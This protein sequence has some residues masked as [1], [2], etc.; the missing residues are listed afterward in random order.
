MWRRRV[1]RSEAGQVIP[2]VAVM[3]G[4]LIGMI[5]FAVDVGS[6]YHD[7]R[8]MQ[9]IADASALAGAESLP[10]D[11]TSA[12]NLAQTYSTK[13]GGP[14]PTVTFPTANTIQVV[15]QT[16]SPAFFSGNSS[17][18]ITAT[19]R[20]S[21][22][23]VS[24]AAGAVPIV[25]NNTQPMLTG[26][27]GL[28]CFGTTTTLK[29]NDDT[30]LGG[31]QTGLIDL[32]SGGDGSVTAG[33]I[34][35]WVTYGLTTPMPPNQFYSSAGSCKFSNQNFHNALDA[36]IGTPL[37]FP[38][39]D[40]LETNSLSN[41]PRYWITGWAAFVVTSYRLN[42]CGNKSDFIQ[43]YFTREV[44]TGASDGTATPDYGVR[45]ISLSGD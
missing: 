11:S 33:Q 38:V 28:P 6:W 30:S 23:Q 10:Y 44:V 29:V 25:V 31:G 14:A 16:Q 34:A 2:F 43:G 18:T 9:A 36:K 13:N 21:A 35:D 37:L 42:G 41:P 1:L 4:G 3:A 17:V 20:A 12:A 22:P 7:H 45:V 32:R 26:C 40:P 27:S 5:A 15:I 8:R 39:Y 24:S 19:A